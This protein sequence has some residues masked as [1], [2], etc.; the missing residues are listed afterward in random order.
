MPFQILPQE[1][2]EKLPYYPDLV[3]I[4]RVLEKASEYFPHCEC[5]RAGRA[6]KLVTGLEESVGSYG[7]PIKCNWHVWNFDEDRGLYIDLTQDQFLK[8]L[9]PITILPSTTKVLLPNEYETKL[10]H[11][12]RRTDS[13]LIQLIRLNFPDV[14]KSKIIVN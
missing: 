9:P 1:E 3:K 14:M 6:V 5:Y 10:Q 7:E 8:S 11:E 13:V 12:E 2:A 4:R